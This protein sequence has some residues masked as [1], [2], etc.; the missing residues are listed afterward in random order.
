MPPELQTNQEPAAGGGETQSDFDTGS[1]LADIS[2]ELFGTEAPEEKAE[3]STEGTEQAA[4]GEAKPDAAA[5][6]SQEENSQ[7]VQEVGAPQTWSKE[8]IAEWATIPDRAK[9]EILKREED[10]F[11][12]L[13]EYKGRAE[14]GDAYSKVAEPYKPVMDKLG[15]N[16][17]DLFQSFAGNHYILSFGSNEQKLALAAN[18]LNTYQID[19]IELATHLGNMPAFDPQKQQLEL[20]N[21]RLQQQLT[22]RQQ[23]EFNAARANIQQQ[24]NAFASDPKNIYFNELSD[25]IAKFIESGVCNTLA[26]AYDKAVYANPVTRQKELDRLTAERK[27]ADEAEASARKAKNAESTAADVRT[28]PN[29]RDGTVPLG[30]MDETMEETLAAIRAR[31]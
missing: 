5:A 29:S 10:M 27:A 1:A 28:R 12:G 8:A 9:Q 16:P 30:S 6:P 19:I 2:S 20:Q 18:L 25:D 17:V 11:R 31:G 26:E 13:E 22:Q 3:K 24:I 7:A 21:Q 23:Q 14:V 15:L 4:P